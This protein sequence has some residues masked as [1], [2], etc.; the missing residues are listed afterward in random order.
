MIKHLKVD[1]SKIFLLATS[2]AMVLIFSLVSV[3]PALA[4]NV[5]ALNA[6]KARIFEH[7]TS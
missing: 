6:N 1:L 4:A 3:Q 5:H 2:L 7:W